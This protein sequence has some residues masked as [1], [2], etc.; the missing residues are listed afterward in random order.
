MKNNDIQITFNRQ[1]FVDLAK[2]SELNVEHI[3][4]LSDV[5]NHEIVVG[6]KLLDELIEVQT[7]LER[8]E[9]MGDDELRAFFIELHRPTPD[10]WGNSEEE[11]AD[12][13]AYNP[14]E[15]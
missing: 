1:F 4:L 5:H 11:I 13:E 3:R 14:M 9:A 15:T 6:G 10:E 7:Q 2:T 12:W 8:L